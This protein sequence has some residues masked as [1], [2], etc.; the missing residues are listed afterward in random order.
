MLSSLLPTSIY[1]HLRIIRSTTH[2]MSLPF[3]IPIIYLATSV[4]IFDAALHCH[5]Q[6]HR[7]YL[8]P[9]FIVSVFLSI[10]SSRYFVWIPG[11]TSLWTQAMLLNLP[12]TICLLY[13]RRWPAPHPPADAQP[14]NILVRFL[15]RFEATYR[16][17]GNPQL[18]GVIP[19]AATSTKQEPHP[20]SVF[21]FLRLAKLPIYYYINFKM[22]PT[23][24]SKVLGNI[25]LEDVAE[26][27]QILLRRLWDVSTRELIIRAYVSILWIW[28]SLVYLDGA[29]S[30]LACVSVVIGLNRPSDWP[31]L[32]GNPTSIISLRT[33]WSQFWHKIA[34]QPYTYIGRALARQLGIPTNSFGCKAFVAFVIF[35]LSGVSHGLVS[36]SIGRDGRTDVWW[37][38]LNFLACLAETVFL[39]CLLRATG[40]S[41]EVQLIKESW[42]GAFI[43][44]AWV[45]A[46][47][48]WS[49]PKWQYSAM[50]K[51][52]VHARKMAAW[53]SIFSKMQAGNE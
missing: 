17:W 52:A 9:F 23:L 15:H 53:N 16:L 39:K 32:F 31:S 28:Q 35:G 24:V 36:W 49:V 21:L 46:F 29:N 33:F 40:H 27:K 13:M 18:I 34:V 38:I 10:T 42:F 48:F 22:L 14:L 19:E 7:Y 6:T 3:C 1:P 5:N 11:L 47:F 25:S 45:F 43:G 44:R 26:V 8:L 4:L 30:I 51:E 2:R 41:R 20:T 37:F 12:H 50:Y